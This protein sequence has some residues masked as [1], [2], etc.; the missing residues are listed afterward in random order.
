MSVGKR[1]DG[2]DLKVPAA[3][4]SPLEIEREIQRTRQ[5]MGVHL[6]ALGHKLSPDRL[7]RQARE[8]VSEKARE[9]RSQAFDFVRRHPVPLAAAGV[10]AVVLALRNGR[11]DRRD[12]RGSGSFAGSHPLGLA[13]VTGVVG[14]ALGVMAPDAEEVR[15]ST[16]GSA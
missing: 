3:E 4:A 13:F 8:V 15:Y 1:P 7:K 2:P 11:R 16:R 9:T 6:D 14:L 10:G 5:R 12:R